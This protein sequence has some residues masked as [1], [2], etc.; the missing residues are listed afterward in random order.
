MN[1]SRWINLEPRKLEIVR[2]PAEMTVERFYERFPSSVALS[3][4]LLI[5][6]MESGQVIPE[7]T[8]MKRVTGE[9]VPGD[10]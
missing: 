1:E 3:T 6:G 10:E 2:V 9:G 4:I 7:G 8:L 5:N